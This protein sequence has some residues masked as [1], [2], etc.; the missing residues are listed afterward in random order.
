MVRRLVL[1]GVALMTAAPALAA[2]AAVTAS[3]VT[4]RIHDYAHVS[5]RQ[6]QTAQ[7]HVSETFA[8]IGIDAIWRPAVRTR[9]PGPSQAR[10]NEPE[11]ASLVVMLITGDM[12]DRIRLPGGVAGYAATAADETGRVAFVVADRTE[13]IARQGPVAHADV[14]GGVMAHEVA[15]LLLPG[16]PHSAD[17]MMRSKWL[18]RDFI[19]LERH[20]FSDE[21]IV[22]IRQSV[23]SLARTPAVRMAD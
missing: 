5:S 13:K 20:L 21:E 23:A 10:E 16:R 17:G 2:P 9:D 4:I 6:I 3:T 1:A 7:D 8:R 14:L 22:I 11:D 15:H 12:A 18:P 19:D